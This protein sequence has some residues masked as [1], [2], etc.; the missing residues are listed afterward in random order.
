MI[1]SLVKVGSAK[2]GLIYLKLEAATFSSSIKAL[3][4]FN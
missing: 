1:I 4:L 2:V 3:K